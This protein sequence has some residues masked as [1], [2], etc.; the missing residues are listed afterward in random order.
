M[1]SNQF[2][3][4]TEVCVGCATSGTEEYES[5]YSARVVVSKVGS[6]G[7]TERQAAEIELVPVWEMCEKK[8]DLGDEECSIVRYLWGIRVSSAEEVEAEDTVACLNEVRC[9][10]A[11]CGGWGRDAVYEE[12]LLAVFG[13]ELVVADGTVGCVEVRAVWEDIGW[14]WL[15]MDLGGCF[16]NFGIVGS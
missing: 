7:T 15:V 5:V 16:E 3:C 6:D 12:K 9:D 10:E 2:D 1:R 4:W 11:P 13:A 8:G 14:V